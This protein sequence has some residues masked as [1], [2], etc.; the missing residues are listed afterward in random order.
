MTEME[1]IAIKYIKKLELE[2]ETLKKS[3]SNLSNTINELKD[4]DKQLLEDLKEARNE[5]KQLKE[6]IHKDTQEKAKLKDKIYQDEEE[7]RKLNIKLNMPENTSDCI[8]EWFNET[9]QLSNKDVVTSLN[10]LWCSFEEWFM[11]NYG[12]GKIDKNDFKKYLVY[13]QI[14]CEYGWTEINH[15]KRHPRFNLIIKIND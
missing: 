14:K 2:N 3:N 5:I 6:Q 1:N 8:T 13:W 11:A 15:T 7:K 10:T 4:N 12:V 9:V